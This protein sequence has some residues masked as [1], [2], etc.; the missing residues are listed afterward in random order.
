MWSKIKSDYDQ[1]MVNFIKSDNHSSSFAEAAM[2][3]IRQQ[4]RERT[5]L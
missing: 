4:E 1:A 3:E 2:H 5:K